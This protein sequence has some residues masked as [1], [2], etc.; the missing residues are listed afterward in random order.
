MCRLTK[1]IK[2]NNCG[3]ESNIWYRCKDSCLPNDDPANYC[4]DCYQSLGIRLIWPLSDLEN[5]ETEIND[6]LHA[7]KFITTGRVS[8]T[9]PNDSNTP[10]ER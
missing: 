6:K 2:C 7:D 3:I 4:S 8:P 9:E 1:T 10:K 5:K